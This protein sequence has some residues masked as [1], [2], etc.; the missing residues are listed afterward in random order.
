MFSQAD[1]YY[2]DYDAAAEPAKNGGTRNGRTVWSVNVTGSRSSHTASFPEELAERVIRTACP[3][4]GAVLDPFAG[5]GTV[6]AVAQRLNRSSIS[7]EL[8]P[9]YS[10]HIANRLSG[11]KS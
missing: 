5:S 7:I 6:A 9:E 1:R 2:Y 11:D 10:A 8:N 4:S 3:P